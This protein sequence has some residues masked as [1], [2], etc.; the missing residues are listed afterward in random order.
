MPVSGS[1]GADGARRASRRARR[2]AGRSR[3][4]CPARRWRPPGTPSEDSRPGATLL[5]RVGGVE[6]IHHHSDHARVRHEVAAVHV[7]L[8]LLAGGRAFL[9]AARSE[10]PAEM[11][12]RPYFSTMSSH[13]VPLPEAGAPAI[14]ALGA[15][16]DGHGP[17]ALRAGRGGTAGVKLGARELS[18]GG[19]E[20]ERSHRGCGWAR[21]ASVA[22]SRSDKA[23]SPRWQFRWLRSM[24]SG[25][26][27]VCRYCL[28]ERPSTPSSLACRRSPSRPS[29]GRPRGRGRVASRFVPRLV[30]SR[31]AKAHSLHRPSVPAR[32]TTTT[33][34][35]SSSR[36]RATPT[37]GRGGG[38]VRRARRREPA[39]SGDAVRRRGRRRP[40]LPRRPV[41]RVRVRELR[42]GGARARVPTEVERCSM[43]LWMA[44]DD[45][46]RGRGRRRRLVTRT[47]Q[48]TTWTLYY[49]DYRI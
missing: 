21:G 37:R 23:R 27:T 17:A 31:L 6:R 33:R 25:G 2:G 3:A 34:W 39:R 8:R 47:T 45:A 13:C 35:S 49:V 41:R 4:R 14:I 7:L 11:C 18:R 20:G 30:S 40:L 12:T 15:G 5:L 1:G 44:L 43:R 19:G 29:P 22:T 28:S 9:T 46:F 38:A 42:D 48:R 10:S 36:A 26:R 32:P 24:K 16:A